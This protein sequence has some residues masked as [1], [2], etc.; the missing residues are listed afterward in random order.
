VL[1][2]RG[3]TCPVCVPGLGLDV[4]CCS[5]RL[6]SPTSPA[7]AGD[8]PPGG[9]GESWPRR[10]YCLKEGESRGQG[11]G[12][13]Y[14]DTEHTVLELLNPFATDGWELVNLQDYREGGD[15]CS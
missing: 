4:D 7:G 9:L 6:S 13:N 5:R 8:R 14:S 10:R 1:G 3:R 2:G 12:E 15:A 11:V